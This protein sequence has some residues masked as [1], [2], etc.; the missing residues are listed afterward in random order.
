MP[1]TS[2][3]IRRARPGDIDEILAMVRELAEYERLA[4][5]AVAT[6]AQFHAALFGASP[7]VYAFVVDDDS[8]AGTLAGFAIY[9]L[10]FS[11]WLGV[12]GLYLEDLYVRPQFRGRGF[13]KRLLATMARVCVDEGYGRF[14]W[15]VLDWN[16]DALAVYESIG[17][18]PMDEWTVQRVTGQALIDLAAQAD[19]L[20]AVPPAQHGPPT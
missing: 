12:H 15:W 1:V 7:A 11:T 16:V 20:P 13:G 19:P 18:V 8:D 3:L 6:P 17:A 10:N 14:E 2:G 4:D 5:Q 9:F